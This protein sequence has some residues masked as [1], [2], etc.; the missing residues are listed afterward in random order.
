MLL[1]FVFYFTSLNYR[2][3]LIYIQIL[4]IVYHLRYMKN[5]FNTNLIVRST[6]EIFSV[7]QLLRFK[8]ENEHKKYK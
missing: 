3:V 6:M 1:H 7:F 2:A 5:V 4:C 8:F